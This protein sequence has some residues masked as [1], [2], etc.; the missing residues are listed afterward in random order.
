MTMQR[1]GSILIVSSRRDPASANIARA[2]ITKNGF[3]QGPGHG[4]ETY[5]KD[6]IR[7]VMLENMGIYVEPN[8]ITAD[9]SKAIFVTKHV[10]SSGSTAFTVHPTDN[11]TKRAK[12]GG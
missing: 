9:V 4:I 1:A 12:Y 11:L 7:L 10:S 5:S 3:E 8:D 2:I 6:N